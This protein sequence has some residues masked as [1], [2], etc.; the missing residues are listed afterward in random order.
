MRVISLRLLLIL[1]LCML[2]LASFSFT[3]DNP[4]DWQAGYQRLAALGSG[5]VVWESSRS[6]DWRIYRIELDGTGLRQLSPEEPGR[7]HYC[8]HLAPDGRRLV[9]QSFPKE[10]NAYNGYRKGTLI[11]LHLLSADGKHDRIIAGDSR[12]VG[13]DRAAIWIDNSTLLYID[14]N[15][16]TRQLNVDTGESSELIRYDMKDSPWDGVAGYLLDPHLNYATTGVPTFSPYD[17]ATQKISLRQDLNG[18]QPYFTSDGKWGF[19][20]RRGGGPVGKI[21][22]S[23][24]EIGSIIERS[25]PRMPPERAY[26]YFPMISADMKLFAVGAS[27]NQHDHFNADYDIFVC[28]INPETLQLIDK[29]VRYTFDPHCDRFPDVHLDEFVLGSWAGEAPYRVKL[30]A[31]SEGQ[32]HWDFGDGKQ[33][34]GVSVEHEFVQEGEYL[35]IARQGEQTLRASVSVA[36][37]QKPV[38]KEAWLQDP[39]T[40]AVSFS[41][42]VY[43]GKL[44]ASLK[45]ELGLQ[46]ASLSGQAMKLLL[47]LRQPVTG[48]VKL[49]LENITDLAQRPNKLDKIT[50]EI[51]P[52]SW[53]VSNQG[54]VFLFE[55]AASK[56]LVTDPQTGQQFSY[57]LQP[58]G[59][60]HMDH[61]WALVLARGAY[62]VEGAGQRLLEACKASGQLTIETVLVPDN[63]TQTGPARIVTLSANPG[64]RNFT[65]GQDADHLAL[66]LR[67]PATGPNG[68]NPQVPF[69]KLVAGRPAHVVITYMPGRLAAFLNGAK[70]LDTDA[71][72]G[73]FSNWTPYEL[74][75]GDEATG[76]RDWAGTLSH[77]AL[78]ARALPDDVALQA[79]GYLPSGA[80]VAASK[81]RVK[82]LSRS[83]LPTLKQILPYRGALVN[84]EVEVLETLSGKPLKG[85]VRIAQWSLLDGQ[86]LALIPAKPGDT[87]V[88]TIEP[89][90][91]NPQLE[92]I[93]LSDT[94]EADWEVP[95]YY[96]VNPG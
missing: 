53:P 48:P 58:R 75:L 19:W 9:Y 59:L 47:K 35:V 14:G 6:G 16:I 54:L 13:E 72:Q 76:D 94:L 95:Q 24:G 37:S 57:P 11:P 71:V 55:N 65:L 17:T 64:E 74:L 34:S 39:T 78:Y 84:C 86:Q 69:G 88:L 92:S 83:D 96:D 27:P 52:V 66:R 81:V 23:D 45:P 44:K 5:F 18:C 10:L 77:V 29:P 20:M 60:G 68:A 31:P 4:S 30:A 21:R 36:P 3:Q 42:P 51:A 89:F 87:A 80:E 85:K 79:S 26:L 2:L 32:W 67:T 62:K 46:S 70:V 63:I 91:A 28:Q 82:L 8:P 22:L 1:A 33:D 56:N 7:D 38:V 43:T 25:D 41:E 93:L 50:V 40:L 90:E 61:S 12:A 49:T 73:D 15:N